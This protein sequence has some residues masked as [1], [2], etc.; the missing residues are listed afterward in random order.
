[1]VGI[2]WRDKVVGI[3]WR[4]GEWTGGYEGAKTFERALLILGGRENF[5]REEIVLEHFSRGRDWKTVFLVL[6]LRNL[7]DCYR[8]ASVA[9][10]FG[11]GGQESL[12]NPGA[13]EP[14]RLCS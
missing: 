3:E 13:R 14:D 2:E 4:G 10:S 9:G 12:R 5:W 6:G 7:L 1:V 11:L 8:G